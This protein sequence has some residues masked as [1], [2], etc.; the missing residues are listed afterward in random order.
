MVM[1]LLSQIPSQLRRARVKSARAS[2]ND[3]SVRAR[4]SSQ[5]SAVDRSVLSNFFPLTES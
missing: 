1:T 3:R 5:I 4:H 2:Q